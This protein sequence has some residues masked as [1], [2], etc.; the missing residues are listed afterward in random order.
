[1]VKVGGVFVCLLIV[2]MDIVA[3]ILGIEAELEQNKVKQLRLWIF[4][5]R[6]PSHPAFKLGLGAAALLV[7]AHVIA[8][9]LGGCNNCI[10]SQ[11]ELQKAPPNRQLSLACL[12]FTWVILAVGLSMLVKGARSSLA[13]KGARTP[14]AEKGAKFADSKA[15]TSLEE[16]GTQKRQKTKKN[17]RQREEEGETEGRRRRGRGRRRTCRGNKKERQREEERE[18]EGDRGSK[19]R[20]RWRAS[21]EGHGYRHVGCGRPL[22]GG[23]VHARWRVRARGEI[24]CAKGMAGR[25]RASQFG[26]MA[27]RDVTRRVIVRAMW[28]VSPRLIG[29]CRYVVSQSALGWGLSLCGVAAAA[30]RVILRLIGSAL[31]WGLSRG[32]QSVRAWLGTVVMWRV[33]PRLVGDCR[34][35][36]SQSALGWGLWLCGVVAAAWRVSPLLIG[37]TRH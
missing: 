36:A 32:G 10:C 35:V 24:N 14:L 5:C 34:E 27:W 15:R 16:K 11:D 18:T 4:E 33:S 17:E 12:V 31:D 13:G 3:G 25:Y 30:W 22:V 28:R 2:A 29:D 19:L 37:E 26:L 21:R 23:A 9:L 7:L 8:N 1:M 6:E 20:Y